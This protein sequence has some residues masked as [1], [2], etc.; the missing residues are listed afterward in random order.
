MGK[1]SSEQQYLRRNVSQG[2]VLGSVLF[3]IAITDFSSLLKRRGVCFKLNADDTAV[4]GTGLND[5]DP[6]KTN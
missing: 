3:C 4:R 1:V 2:N 5:I 6:T